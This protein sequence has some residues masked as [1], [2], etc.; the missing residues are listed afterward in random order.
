MAWDAANT[1]LWPP[2]YYPG[3][4]AVQE[5]HDIYT[6][7]RAALVQVLQPP[8]SPDPAGKK[9]AAAKGGKGAAPVEEAAPIITW[10][11]TWSLSVSAL[12]HLLAE[13]EAAEATAA[14]AAQPPADA[15]DSSAATRKLQSV[16]LKARLA[17]LLA[18]QSVRVPRDSRVLLRH[19]VRAALLRAVDAVDEKL[20]AVRSE[21]DQRV[22]E[23]AASEGKVQPPTA[24]W[25]ADKNKTG[26]SHTYPYT[27]S[28]T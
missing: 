28:N 10:P 16:A 2:V 27:T 24:Q 14:A 22:A 25:L 21:Y 20:E 26:A 18:S 17:K 15:A 12:E 5:A 8:V 6:A 7:A 13:L 19:A 3:P 4:A 11:E 23:A 1:S 9:P